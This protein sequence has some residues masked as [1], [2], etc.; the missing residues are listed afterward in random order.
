[1]NKRR[2]IPLLLFSFLTLIV[3]QVVSSN[4]LAHTIDWDVTAAGGGHF[5]QG[6]YSLD[7]TIGQ[8]VV[9]VSSSGS[10]EL[11]EGYW[12]V[13]LSPVANNNSYTTDEDV[14]LT[15]PAPGVLGNDT[16]ADSGALT[17][18]LN[19][20]TSDG[21]LTLNAN[22]SFIYV[23]DPGFSG[24]DSFTY[25]ASDGNSN[26]NVAT[27]TITV[28][29]LVNLPPI[30]NDDSYATD[31][32][33]TLTVPAPG[34]LDNDTD[35]DSGTL[36]AVLNTTTSDGNLTLNANGSFT[37]VP[38]PGFNGSDSF[39]YRASDGNSN[40]NVASVTITVNPGTS[41]IYLPAV[42]LL[43]VTCMPG[44]FEIEPNNTS[45]EAVN[46][47]PLCS[48]QTYNGYPNDAFDIFY[49]DVPTTGDITISL[50]NH[51]G[52]NVQLQL[53]YQNL[54]TGSLVQF[55]FTAPYGFAYTVPGGK[56][57]PYYVAI[58]TE[59]NYNSTT[60]YALTVTYP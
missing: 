11:S 7:N 53:Y 13:N 25:R 49:L 44:P 3:A 56:I 2:L 31:E 58:F 32:D 43:E 24:S 37:Y 4:P 28:D 9:G 35:A 29:P 23:P 51:T 30:A 14:T 54:Q 60:P 57:G 17:A 55:D 20:T 18:V 33:V 5:N 41:Y 1:M 45:I 38:D 26:S 27:V 40:S 16:D 50:N 8:P 46:N 21:N 42:L 52:S 39:T 10:S 15:V 19:T 6:I 48:G 59:S 36:T 22:G 12:F 47:L 34:V